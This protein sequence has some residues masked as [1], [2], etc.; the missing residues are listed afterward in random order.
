MVSMKDKFFYINIIL[1]VII[2][3]AVIALTSVHKIRYDSLVNENKKREVSDN[4]TFENIENI[5]ID[6]QIKSEKKSLFVQSQKFWNKSEGD[7]ARFFEILNN[8]SKNTGINIESFSEKKFDGKLFIKLQ[9]SGNSLGIIKFFRKLENSP[10]FIDIKSVS[11][12]N[13]DEEIKVVCDLMPLFVPEYNEKEVY[14]KK[15]FKENNEVNVSNL[16]YKL[17]KSFTTIKEKTYSKTEN[18][19]N[20]LLDSKNKNK[21]NEFEY[22]GSFFQNNIKNH[23]LKKT[24]TGEIIIIN[25]LNQNTNIKLIEDRGKSIVIE[26]NLKEVIINCEIWTGHY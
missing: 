9:L 1:I 21:N 12:R 26:N 25:K 19:N 17:F 8:Y 13:I 11:I 4:I 10:K 5:D 3:F 6:T 2:L 20:K 15:E 7:S 14:K 16:V 23:I 18:H 24:E 22:F